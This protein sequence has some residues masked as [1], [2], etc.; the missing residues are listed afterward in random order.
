[1]AVF[2]WGHIWPTITVFKLWFKIF[3]LLPLYSSSMGLPLVQI[4][5]DQRRAVWRKKAYFTFVSLP[6][7]AVKQTAARPNKGLLY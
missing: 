7:T 5:D 1:L 6:K 4:S 3:W 2:P